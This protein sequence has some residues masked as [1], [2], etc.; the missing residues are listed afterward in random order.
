MKPNMA[1][2]QLDISADLTS[3]DP[4]RQT[5]ALLAIIALISAG[6]DG[7]L[8]VSQVCQHILGNSNVPPGLRIKG[9]DILSATN[10]TDVDFSRISTAILN[11]IKIDGNP[12]LHVAALRAMKQLP[13]H[14]LVALLSDE[15]SIKLMRAELDHESPV[16]RGAAAQSIAMAVNFDAVLRT[17]VDN[18]MLKKMVDNF[19][20][21][22]TKMLVE[23]SGNLVV[24][25]CE[26]LNSMLSSMSVRMGA[27]PVAH[28]KA[29]VKEAKSQ[30]SQ[31]YIISEEICQDIVL[32]V[33]DMF[34]EIIARLRDLQTGAKVK[35]I[36]F[37][38]SY[39]D[40]KKL[41]ES[42]K[43]FGFFSGEILG[44][45]FDE[46]VHFFSECTSSHD[47]SLVVEATKGL[48]SLVKVGAPHVN[49]FWSNY[50]VPDRLIIL[51]YIVECCRL[52]RNLLCCNPNC[53]RQSRHQLIARASWKGV[54]SMWHSKDSCLCSYLTWMLFHCHR[55]LHY[56]KS[57]LQ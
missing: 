42:Q 31:A 26:S 8:Y 37:L 55:R 22:V 40:S 35:V 27:T 1:S 10:P 48:L 50:F 32:C 6:R 25:A 36:P 41:I 13:I 44:H 23:K 52:T 7:T 49:T 43:R 11:D 24:I 54:T 3:G 12:E 28:N 9:Y 53:Q 38:V 56:S 39:L 47:P 45:Q 19:I 4:S 33:G 17:L 51:I 30:Y 20:G 57:F 16:I 29:G 2:Q 14:R 21:R 5:N 46:V 34:A 18:S 15:D